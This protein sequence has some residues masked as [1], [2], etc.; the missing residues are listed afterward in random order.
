VFGNE[1][2][3]KTIEEEVM[4][5][6]NEMDVSTERHSFNL[7]QLISVPITFT[8]HPALNTD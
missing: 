2:V 7:I 5:R 6:R 4:G 8:P 1:V 3:G